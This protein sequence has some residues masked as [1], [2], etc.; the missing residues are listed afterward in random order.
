MSQN[1]DRKLRTFYTPEQSEFLCV[2][3]TQ[4]QYPNLV[5]CSTLGDQIGKT[6]SEVRTW[7]QNKRQSVK[8][9]QKNRIFL[10]PPP[11]PLSTA[12]NPSI[13]QLALDLEI[14][15]NLLLDAVSTTTT[16]PE[17]NIG[18]P[19]PP[20]DLVEMFEKFDPVY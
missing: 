13:A 8:R 18:C 1:T 7:F 14:D 9:E 5:E 12:A 16:F 6:S 10:T 3:F 19:S 17:F 4:K 15:V 20:L 2:A 11:E